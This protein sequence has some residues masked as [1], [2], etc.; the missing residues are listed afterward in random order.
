MSS[1]ERPEHWSELALL[2]DKLLDATPE[3]RDA[4]IEALSA[5]DP[6]R[7]LELE[8]LRAEC[9]RVKALGMSGKAA[10]H[11]S[12]VATIRDAFTPTPAEIARARRI[13]ELFRAEPTRP[14]VF[15]GKLFE[16]PAIKRLERV[17]DLSDA[18]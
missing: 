1:S 9:E 18:Q 11:A 16:L 17:A 3:E 2:V 10:T 15:E 8:A 4:L 7:Q 12:Q 13:V 6:R 5:G 14:L